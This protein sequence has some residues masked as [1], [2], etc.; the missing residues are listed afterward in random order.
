MPNEQIPTLNSAAEYALHYTERLKLALVPIPHGQKAPQH[1]GWNEPEKAVTQPEA[2]RERWTRWPGNMGV[3]HAE[4][5]TCALDVD[6]EEGARLA[7]KAIGIDL[8]ALLQ[9]NPY[10]IKGAK[11]EKPLYRVPAGIELKRLTLE[12][13]SPPDKDAKKRFTV[14]ELRGGSVQDV[15]PPSIHPDTRKPYRWVGSVPPGREALL[16][17]PVPLLHLWMNWATFKPALDAACPWSTAPALSAEESTCG[18]VIESFNAAFG[19]RDV[20]E[21]NGYQPAGDDRWLAPSSSTGAAAVVLLPQK[22]DKGHEVVYS[23]HGSDPLCNGR[24]HDAFSI[25]TVLEHGGDNKAAVR[26]AAA[27]LGIEF[28]PAPG[29]PDVKA[30]TAEAPPQ[31]KSAGSR[32]FEY[33]RDGGAEFWHDEKANAYASVG[34]GAHREHYK[35]PSRGARDFLVELVYEREGAVFSGLGQQ[36]ALSLMEAFARR[37][38]TCH[39]SGVRVRRWGQSTYLDLCNAA[40]EV[41]EVDASGWRVISADQCPVRFARPGHMLPLPAPERGGHIGDLG[42]FLNTDERGLML[43]TAFLLAVVSGVSPYPVLA[44]SGEQG[45]GKSTAATVIRHLVDPSAATRRRVPKEERDLFVGAQGT[46]LLSYDNLSSIPTW[47][48]DALC[49]L[50]TGG[51][52]TAR[53]LHSNDEETVLEA[54][55]PVIVNGIPDLL[56]RPDLAERALTVT[57][58]RIGDKQ[59]LTEQALLTRYE[60]ARPRLLG[61]LL[62]ALAGGL[63]RL[64]ETKLERAPRLADFVQLI[65]AS[66]AALSWRAGAFLE[67]YAAM[68]DEAAGSVLDGDPVA[69]ALRTLL[70]HEQTWTGTVKTLLEALN[71][72]QG[73]GVDGKRPP[74]EWP[75]TARMLGGVLRRLAPPLGKLGYDVAHLGRKNDGEHYRLHKKP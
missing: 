18:S 37:K 65:V 26:Q 63:A 44:L 59:R 61:S 58:R 53:T 1:K 27:V 6:D 54:V 25:S 2:A 14:L 24:S 60:Q 40:W 51:A 20:L 45:T 67:A 23:H 71:A 12:W 75:R 13:P 46:H 36:E 11:G 15:L 47:M 22:N 42:Q 7:L 28:M 55:R 31:R 69:D 29:A 8:D 50:S 16:E 49:A 34:T 43:C 74:Q 19:V 70:D 73:H 57:L 64:P 48:S 66:E 30:E 33:V 72:Q 9:A 62:D 21:R 10:R 39:P 68:Q 4:S 35:L 3:L 52:F 38:G 17:L 41:V 5:G 32:A 56:A